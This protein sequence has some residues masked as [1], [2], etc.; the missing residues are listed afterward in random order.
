MNT[1]SS[2]YKTSKSTLCTPSMQLLVLKAITPQKKLLFM[3]TAQ[4]NDD[5]DGDNDVD[6]DDDD[7]VDD[8]DDEEED[9]D[10]T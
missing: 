2:N 10:N 7:D 8:D 3:N 5:G 1:N 6:D 9:D 4:C